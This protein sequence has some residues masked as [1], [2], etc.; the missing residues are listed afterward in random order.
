M[1]NALKKWY[2]YLIGLGLVALVAAIAIIPYFAIND[3][4]FWPRIYI[5]YISLFSGVV[6]A[7]GGFIAQ[8]IYR[9]MKRKE[10]KNWDYP[11][12]DKYINTAWRIYF[13]FLFAAVVLVLAGLISYLFLR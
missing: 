3:S 8:D 10:T 1:K 6:F 5:S 11:L 13:P 4:S 7:G 2:N 12:E 9:A